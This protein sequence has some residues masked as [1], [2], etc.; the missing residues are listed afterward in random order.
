MKTRVFI[1]LGIILIAGVA[2]ALG[3][4]AYPRPGKPIVS[5]QRL[6]TTEPTKVLTDSLALNCAR[7]ALALDGLDTNLWRPVLDHRLAAWARSPEAFT[8]RN[9]NNSNHVCIAFRR[10]NTPTRF[11]SVYLVEGTITCQSSVE[12]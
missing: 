5:L 4:R 7:Q 9:R 3:L 10:N 8:A 12:K 1:L 2:V 6:M 11:V